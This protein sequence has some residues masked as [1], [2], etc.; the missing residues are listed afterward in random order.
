MKKFSYV[1]ISIF[2]ISC[3][4]NTDRIVKNIEELHQIMHQG[5]LQGRVR[6][7]TLGGHH[8]YGLGAKD[9]LS[10]EILMSEGSGD[11]ISIFHDPDISATLLVYAKVNEWDTLGILDFQDTDEI[12][13]T[14]AL[15][16]GLN[17]AFPF[18]LIGEPSLP[19]YHVINYDSQNGDIQKHKEDTYKRNLIDQ[20]V[21]VLEFFSSQA[22]GI[23]TYHD[24]YVHMHFISNTK[25][26][27]GHVDLDETMIRTF[28]LLIPKL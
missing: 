15:E 22:Q 7:D 17:E 18:L 12:L 1:L 2:L 27:M 10:G 23:Y 6:L 21:T 25:Q 13:S 9:S 20:S 11:S 8:I 19:E 16:R 14:V 28:E 26:A 3:G 5:K 24:S 4:S